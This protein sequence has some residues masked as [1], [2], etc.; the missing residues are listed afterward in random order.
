MSIKKKISYLVPSYNHEKYL[1]DLLGSIKLDAQSLLVAS[2]LIIID[3]CSTD[4]SCSIIEEWINENKNYFDITFHVLPVN[5]GLTVVLNKLISM[6]SGEFLRFL[7]S[8]DILVEGSTQKL[9]DVFSSRPGLVCSFGDAIVIDGNNDILH[10]SSIAFHGGSVVKLSCPKSLKSELLQNWCL[11]GPS[12]LIKKSHYDF[13][14]YDENLS[15]DDYD[16]YLSLLEK[17]DSLLFLNDVVCSYRIHDTNT[18]KTK[19][20][21][22]RIEN[23]NSFL[24]IIDRY[25]DRGSLENELL[26]VKYKTIAKINYLKSNYAVSILCLIVSRLFQVKNIF[27]K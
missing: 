12:F 3:D 20:S 24:S 26:P 21:Q 14:V 19:S 17:K 18:S 13:M 9:L 4:A 22:K 16:L 5:N 10:K 1:S 7:A 27:V 25:I 11:A 6:A 8:D 23:L 2:E 15:I